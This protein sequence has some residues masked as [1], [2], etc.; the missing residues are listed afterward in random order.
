MSSSIPTAPNH[1]YENRAYTA[2]RAW[3]MNPPPG[4]VC[5]VFAADPASLQSFPSMRNGVLQALAAHLRS[6]ST[7]EA[8][9]AVHPL[10]LS[11]WRE[12]SHWPTDSI[13]SLE[14]IGADNKR[15]YGITTGGI[16]FREFDAVVAGYCQYLFTFA[17][18]AAHAMP[19]DLVQRERWG[20]YSVIIPW[21]DVPPAP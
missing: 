11:D 19:S 20:K 17:L 21:L 13:C 14:D 12:Q 9:I 4:P 16:S 8:N 10:L 3:L 5:V 2:A 1:V 18:D 6:N 15:R 7:L